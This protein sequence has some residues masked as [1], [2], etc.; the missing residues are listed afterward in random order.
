MKF[1]NM[2]NKSI[3]AF[4]ALALA[5]MSAWSQSNP[6]ATERAQLEQLRSTTMGL[7]NVLVETGLL[8]R[9]KAELLIKQSQQGAV[10]AAQADDA[11]TNSA[12]IGGK[13]GV[14]RKSV[15][16]IPYV[17]ESLKSEMR[18]DIKREVLAQARSE[19]WGDPGA[20]P[21]WMNRMAFEGD[22]RV[23]YQHEDFSS[24]NAQPLTFYSQTSSPAWAPDLIN[25]QNGRDRMTL[26][27]RLGVTS[28]L[29]FGFKAGL[30]LVT[31]NAGPA[32][33]SQTLGGSDGHGSKYSVWLDRAFLQWDAYTPDITLG[34][35]RMS[36][37]FYGGDLAWPDDLNFD[38]VYANGK[39]KFNDAN[40]VF[41]TAGAFPLQEMETSSRD[42]WLFGAQLGGHFKP[43][44]ASQV[45]VGV[46]LYD[47]QHVEGEYDES[48]PVPTGSAA[49]QSAY[50]GSQYPKSVRQK[51]NTLIR[52]NP[53]FDLGTS[54]VTTPVWGLASKFRPL[55]ISVGYQ[56][57]AME[58]V[59]FKS[60]LDWVRNI[61]FDLED[62]RRRSGVAD[63]ELGQRT[64]ALQARVQLSSAKQ[65]LRGDWSAFL[66][67]RRLE[68]DAW[69]D[70]FTDTT[71]HL[72]GTN[73]SGWSLGGAYYVGPRTSLGVRVTSS[74]NLND[75]VG[76]VNGV[77]NV[78]N[79]T[80]KLDVLQFEVNTRF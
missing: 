2:S 47:F 19:R 72:G 76:E 31:G 59:I 57:N 63:L 51:G 29:K 61:G 68:R 1:M 16:R 33:T 13:D 69:L 42:K 70:A 67:W 73:Y 44:A 74:R 77:P 17:P 18:D 38:G 62:I 39:F 34:A 23:R 21:S 37:P 26:R 52:L 15:I 32:S 12:P 28:D 66:V 5:C 55:V 7:I 35:G 79:S 53:A 14:A 27:A 80:L 54:S 9:D 58:S 48:N 24:D 49:T 50:L 36:N 46:G 11:A 60:S 41:A 4:S 6:M 25:T 75:G 78:S 64:N 20:L 8:S 65:E 10:S 56:N 3:Y 45:S 43:D 71:W 30:R 22:V 40:Q